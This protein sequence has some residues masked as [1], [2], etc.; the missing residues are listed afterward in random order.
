M[1]KHENLIYEVAQ[2]LSNYIY[3]NNLQATKE[4]ME[5]LDKISKK[6]LLTANDYIKIYDDNYYTFQTWKELVEDE[7]R[8]NEG[9]TEEEL[10]AQ[11]GNSV[12]QLPYGWYVQ[13]V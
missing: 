12:W 2:G 13:Y 5:L 7:A 8:Q 1:N 10:K 3:A 9:L 11:I 6:P 4:L